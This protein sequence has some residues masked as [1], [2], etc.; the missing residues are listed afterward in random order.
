MKLHVPLWSLCLLGSLAATTHGLGAQQDPL[1]MRI[2]QVKPRFHVIS[3]FTNGNILVFEGR[4]GLL[5]VD[6]QSA[7]RVGLADSVLRT[8]TRKPVTLVINT[9]YHDDHIEGNP[10]FRARGARIIAQAGL[11]VE[12]SK[13]TTIPEL[14]WHR[15]AAAPEALPDETFDDSLAFDFEGERV[16]LLH[17]PHAHTRGDAMVW[18]PKANLIHT[19][20]VLEREAPP[21]IDAWAGG[22]LDGMIAAMDRVLALANDRTVIIPGHGTPTNREGVLAYRRMLLA[23]RERI[24]ALV[25]EGRTPDQIAAAHPLQEFEAGMGPERWT[26]RFVRLTSMGLGAKN[27]DPREEVLAVVQQLF[28][29]MRTKDTAMLRS[30]FEPGARLTG[31]RPR[32]GGTAVQI[33]TVD[34]FADFVA[35]DQRGAWVERAFDPEVRVER[36]LATVWAAYDFHLGGK[37]SHCG[38]DAVQ[39]LKTA[40]GWKIVALADTYQP[41]G[42]PQ[43]GPPAAE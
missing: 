15:T 38:V 31:L 29:A 35:R 19:G 32:N 37:F 25:R 9:H 2:A 6:A 39:L 12:A 4:K 20:D 3:G 7:K 43:R 26:A 36:T 14:E 10:Y 33:L 1:V 17:P 27:P 13:D 16:I 21:F 22:S 30:V 40:E 11:V 28:D 8:V 23:A 42:C 34:Q 5:L 41:E 18:F 24:G